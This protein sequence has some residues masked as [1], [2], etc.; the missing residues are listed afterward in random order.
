MKYEYAYKKYIQVTTDN[1]IKY[2]RREI[3]CNSD[4][5]YFRNWKPPLTPK[6]IS[7]NKQSLE[8]CILSLDE[9]TLLNSIYIIAQRPFLLKT[10]FTIRYT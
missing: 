1:A 7:A 6:R 4:N 2:Y 5:T 3:I 9:L 10:V 8:N